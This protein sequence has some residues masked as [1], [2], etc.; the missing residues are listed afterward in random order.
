MGTEILKRMAEKN[1]SGTLT[2]ILHVSA[3]EMVSNRDRLVAATIKIT[4]SDFSSIFVFAFHVTKFAV[5][6]SF[7][8]NVKTIQ[9]P[10]STPPLNK[11]KSNVFPQIFPRWLFH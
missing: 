1:D 3:G 5:M 9:L 7:I 8:R 4:L 2:E 10:V 6:N 11:K